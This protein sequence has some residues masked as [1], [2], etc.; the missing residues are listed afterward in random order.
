MAGNFHGL[1]QITAW[2]G[3]AEGSRRFRNSGRTADRAERKFPECLGTEGRG[4]ADFLEG[5]GTERSRGRAERKVPEGPGT[6]GRGREERRRWRL[7]R[8]R[9]PSLGHRESERSGRAG[10]WRGRRGRFQK[11]RRGARGR[12]GSEHRGC[13]EGGDG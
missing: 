11:R 8:V 12:G 10:P 7:W 1:R 3:G 13:W 5:L 9:A 2:A 4:G 6:E